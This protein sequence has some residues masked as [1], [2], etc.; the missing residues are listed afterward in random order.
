METEPIEILIVEDSPTQ[1]TQ[2]RD[3]LERNQF[4]VRLAVHGAQALEALQ[5]RLPRVVISDIVM[6]EMDG[7]ELCRRIKSD[8]RLKHLPVILLTALSDLKD[9]IKGLECFADS[10][11][12]KPYEEQHLLSRIEYILANEKLRA[13]RPGTGVDASKLELFFG[14]HSHF[15]S[16]PPKVENAIDLLLGAYETLVEKNVALT[17]S[18][19]EADH[20]NRAKSEFLSRMSHELRTPMN[21]IL[22]FAQLLEM[23]ETDSGKCDSLKQILSGGNHLLSLIDEVLDI[24]RI[25]AGHLNIWPEPVNVQEVLRECV[26]LIAP[27]AKTRCIRIDDSCATA[28]AR[29]VQADRQR[30][31]QVILNLLSNAVKYNRDAGSVTLSCEQ[32]ET[33]RMRIKI[34]DTGHGIAQKD[35]PR[36]FAVFERLNA[37]SRG[38]DGTG[39]G[40]ALSK[41]LVELMGGGIGVESVAGEGSVFWVE[42][43]IADDPPKELEGVDQNVP[44]RADELSAPSRTVLYIE[45]NLSNLNLVERL[46]ARRSGVN[47]ISAMQGGLGLDLAR[48][49]RPDLIVLDL[50]LPDIPGREV[51]ARLRADS[52]TSECPV[53]VISADATPG[54]IAR[55]RSA[56]A[57]NYLTKPLDVRQFLAFVDEALASDLCGAIP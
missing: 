45:D 54:E 2:L 47:L 16:R 43:D 7:Y 6:P 17:Q 39:L 10:F 49:H 18:K 34:S 23:D 31:K 36:L 30:F 8:E 48:Q 19:E 4:R 25:E 26:D 1:A 40:L 27:L 42:L 56:G 52:A 46:M 28:G 22:G 5:E 57:Q 15:L 55:L 12:V 33:G 21:A 32:T 50:H 11:V 41:K 37:E 35:L 24:S 29:H 44:Q 14:G 13:R 53:V 51:L 9:V 38:V 20:A 3:I